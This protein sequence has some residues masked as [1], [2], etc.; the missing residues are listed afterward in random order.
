M[1]G[2][3]SRKRSVWLGEMGP[4]A[5]VVI[6]EPL[7]VT[8]ESFR[9]TAPLSGGCDRYR[10]WSDDRI[11]L[12]KDRLLP[13]INLEEPPMVLGK[14]LRETESELAGVFYGYRG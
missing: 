4:P 8:F 14:S 6:S 2:P 9:E 11:Y 3:P 12:P 7:G 1:A 5:V 13:Q 10:A